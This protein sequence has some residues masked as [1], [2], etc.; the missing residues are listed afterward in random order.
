MTA[1]LFLVRHAIYDGIAGFLAGRSPGIRLGSA[2]LAQAQRLG[3]R[4]AHEQTNDIFSSPRERAQET[5]AIIANA[6]GAE[7]TTV[8]DALD[9]VDFGCWS[10]R[11]FDDLNNEPDWRRWNNSRSLCRAPGGESIL[12]VQQRVLSL[13]EKLA[14][15]RG[16]AFILVSHSEV[17]KSVVI[18]YLGLSIDAWPRFEISP[19][20]ITTLVFGEC[21]A[22]LLRLNESV[23]S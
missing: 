14:R 10:G 9:E 17:I 21:G 13:V 20:S 1:S 7:E 15:K 5:A 6:C 4:L 23:T 22:K 12:D 3:V 18:Y 19:A 8:T 16:R 11:T 2:G